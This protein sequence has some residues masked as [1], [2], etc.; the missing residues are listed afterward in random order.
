MNPTKRAKVMGTNQKRRGE[1]QSTSTSHHDHGLWMVI[2]CALPLALIVGLSFL[3][4]LGS[5]GYYGLIML[6]PVMH[7]FLMR[8]M[9]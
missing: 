7:Y 3:G 8:K 9:H 6:C 2:C 5:W 4:V 1:E